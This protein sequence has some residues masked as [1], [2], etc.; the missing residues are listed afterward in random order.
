MKGEDNMARRFYIT[1]NWGEV[2][3][4]GYFIQYDNGGIIGYTHEGILTGAASKI[5]E[6]L[7]TGWFTY[8]IKK[9][10][11]MKENSVFTIEGEEGTIE[12][13][14]YE[15]LYWDD[16]ATTILE[17]ARAKAKTFPVAV[18]KALEVFLN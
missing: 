6:T 18:Q 17:R 14:I 2:F 8:P 1:F 3:Y 9:E 15:K 13:A 10:Y 16:K 5:V 12:V 7:K 11:Y 4:D